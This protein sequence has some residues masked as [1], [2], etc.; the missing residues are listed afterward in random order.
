MR[1]SP[2]ECR[3]RLAAARHVVLAT[4]GADGTPHVVPM[5]FA[6]LPP[7]GPAGAGHAAIVSV[8]DHKPKS[9]TALRRLRTIAQNPHVAVLADRY[10]DDWS[11]LWWVRADG[12]ARVVAA[13]SPGADLHGDDDGGWSVA[14]AALTERYPQY[15]RHRPDGP[16]IRIE[17]ERWSGWAW[18]EGP[19]PGR[20]T[21]DEP[22][23]GPGWGDDP[24]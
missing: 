5:T 22:D 14:V 11:R 15:A 21:G 6:V 23:Q 4:A 7:H 13:P 20:E 16:M 17:V 10:D 12:V 3:E 9:T 1:L 8:V 24:T 2:A 18:G 19:L